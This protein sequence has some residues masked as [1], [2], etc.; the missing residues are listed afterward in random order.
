MPVIYR[1]RRRGPSVTVDV[2]T[3]AQD[4]GERG[5]SPLKGKGDFDWGPLPED[6]EGEKTKEEKLRN[7]ANAILTDYA[8]RGNAVLYDRAREDALVA[9]LK[10]EE[11]DDLEVGDDEL[12]KL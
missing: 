11:G 3:I 6:P 5:V 10:K 7:L 8:P 9:L 1:G 12:D 2:K 4:M